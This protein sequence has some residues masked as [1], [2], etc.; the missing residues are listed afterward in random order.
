MGCSPLLR[1]HTIADEGSSLYLCML[2]P[3]LHNFQHKVHGLHAHLPAVDLHICSC[4]THTLLPKTSIRLWQLTVEIMHRTTFMHV[5]MLWVHVSVF[6]CVN[7]SISASMQVCVHVCVHVC[8]CGVCVRVCVCV[9]VCVCV[10]YWAITAFCFSPSHWLEAV[11]WLF[12]CSLSACSSSIFVCSS[13]NLAEQDRQ[14]H[15]Q[16]QLTHNLE[17]AAL[18]ASAALQSNPLKVGTTQT[19]SV[20]WFW[21]FLSWLCTAI[22]HAITV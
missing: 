1:M 10:T 15:H 18:H 11:I 22:N 13:C 20:Q 9:C 19:I 21:G 12:I 7:I 3:N 5:Y 16:T 17:R 8:M 14:T 2:L 6:V 4:F